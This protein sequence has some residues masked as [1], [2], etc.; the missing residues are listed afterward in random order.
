MTGSYSALKLVAGLA[1]AVAAVSIVMVANGVRINLTTSV[2]PGIYV[3]RPD[4]AYVAV[5]LEGE[6]SRLAKDRR[7]LQRGVCPGGLAPI[8]KMVVARPGDVVQITASGVSVNG[9]TLP[10]T[11]PRDRDSRG[12]LMPSLL[13]GKTA[14]TATM[15][16]G[17]LWISSSY[18][19]ASYDSRYY[20][21]V[22]ARQV[23]ARLAPLW[24]HG[25]M[26]Q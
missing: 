13:M 12:R 8:L 10:D 7:Y 11:T 19:P 17:E 24:I 23:Q 6:A 20:G 1:A 3:A 5:C 25:H 15:Q 14:Y 21:P 18:N 26:P 4:G 22:L 9:R 2:P 16:E